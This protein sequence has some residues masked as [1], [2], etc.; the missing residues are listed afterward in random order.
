VTDPGKDRTTIASPDLEVLA[1]LTAAR[2]ADRAQEERRLEQIDELNGA[3]GA[4]SRSLAALSRHTISECRGSHSKWDVT[5]DSR[6]FYAALSAYATLVRKLAAEYGS[7]AAD[8]A[9]AADAGTAKRQ[10]R[11]LSII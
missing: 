7:P 5:E 8:A 10:R 1:R 4:L 3:V 2:F 9:D 11:N 6:A